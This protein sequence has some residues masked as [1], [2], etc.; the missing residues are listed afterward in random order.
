VKI[1]GVL[2]DVGEDCEGWD[3]NRLRLEGFSDDI[4]AAIDAV[5]KR[6]TENEDYFAFIDRASRN[7]IGREVKHADLRDNANLER[8]A[9][10]TEIDRQ[11]YEKYRKAMQRIEAAG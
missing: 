5:T 11:R 9:E 3:L 2:H 8:I 4:V 6:P 1:V 7:A 10:P